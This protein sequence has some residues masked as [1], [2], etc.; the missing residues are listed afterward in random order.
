MRSSLAMIE[1][2][3][4]EAV[5]PLVKDS[6]IPSSRVGYAAMTVARFFLGLGMVPYAI[7]KFQAVP[8][9]QRALRTQLFLAAL[10]LHKAV[11]TF[12]NAFAPA[13]AEPAPLGCPNRPA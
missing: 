7:D 6:L 2:S 12:P 3:L 4:S 13:S 5:R 8:Q 9:M 1:R 11:D 10:T